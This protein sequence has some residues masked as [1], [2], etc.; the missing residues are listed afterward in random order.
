[1]LFLAKCKH[2]SFWWGVFLLCWSDYGSGS[3]LFSPEV[4]M[5]SMGTTIIIVVIALLAVFLVLLL[6][7]VSQLVKTSYQLKVQ[8]KAQLDDGLS[9]LE[10]KFGK[11]YKSVRM[12]LLDEVSR[13]RG[14]QESEIARVTQDLKAVFKES[15]KA[16]R[17]SNARDIQELQRSYD[18]MRAHIEELRSLVAHN[19]ERTAPG[20]VP[21][22]PDAPRADTPRAG[23]DASRAG[24]RHFNVDDLDISDQFDGFDIKDPDMT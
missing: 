5:S 6:H 19:I 11:Q 22:P 21:V 24:Q 3:Y 7:H 10:N 23:D 2:I 4:I 16:V 12:E 9:D 15:E 13:M 8:L 18:I 20:Q 1:L 14:T 17:N